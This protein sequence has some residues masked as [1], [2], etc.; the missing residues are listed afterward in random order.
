M[1]LSHEGKIISS[2]FCCWESDLNT[3]QSQKAEIM[4]AV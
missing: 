3:T 4:Q 1:I 2:V